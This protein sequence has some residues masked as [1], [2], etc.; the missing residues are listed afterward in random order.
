[1]AKKKWGSLGE[2]WG[3]ICVYVCII[4]VRYLCILC[5]QDRDKSLVE[6]TRLAGWLYL[7]V[8]KSC[9]FIY[10]ISVLQYRIIYIHAH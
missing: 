5:R 10:P 4:D 3:I 7:Y 6:H 9:S 2:Y 8:F 1:M